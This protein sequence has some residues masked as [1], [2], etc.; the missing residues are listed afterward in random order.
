MEDAFSC[1]ASLTSCATLVFKL[2]LVQAYEQFWE[3]LLNP[4]Q[5]KVEATC[6]RGNLA[7]ERLGQV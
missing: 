6:D 7:M 1:L 5:L 3:G 4:Y 2:F